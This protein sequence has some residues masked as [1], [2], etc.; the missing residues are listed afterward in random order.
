MVAEMAK[1]LLLSNTRVVTKK[2]IDNGFEF[3]YKK[4]E[5]SF[6]RNWIRCEKVK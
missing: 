6:T 2:L 4:L 1:E 3:K 5:G